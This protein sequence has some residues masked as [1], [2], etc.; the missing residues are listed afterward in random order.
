MSPCLPFPLTES[1]TFDIFNV[2]SDVVRIDCVV[3]G[4]D[5]LVDVDE[6]SMDEAGVENKAGRICNSSI[7]C[8]FHDVSEKH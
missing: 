1:I 4:A 8:D 3:F 5:G 6:K 2:G 7:C